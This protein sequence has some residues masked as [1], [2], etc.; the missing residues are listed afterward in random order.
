[1][2]KIRVPDGKQVIRQVEAS[3]CVYFHEATS[4]KTPYGQAT[5]A[6]RTR[7]LPSRKIVEVVKPVES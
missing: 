1:M 2:G 5:K 3:W 6:C 7:I 4:S